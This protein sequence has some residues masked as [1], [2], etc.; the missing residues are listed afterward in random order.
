M[1]RGPRCPHQPVQDSALPTR[2]GSS[3]RTTSSHAADSTA[4]NCRRRVGLRAG[5]P[6]GALPT[7]WFVV[8]IPGS[9]QLTDGDGGR[10]RQEHPRSE[11]L[12]RCSRGAHPTCL[13]V[14]SRYPEQP[15]SAPGLGSGR[16]PAGAASC[17]V[18]GLRPSLSASSS[19]CPGTGDSS[20]GNELCALSGGPGPTLAQLLS[21]GPGGGT[22]EENSAWG[23]LSG[24]SLAPPV[25]RACLGL[26]QLQSHGEQAASALS[27]PGRQA[28]GPHTRPEAGPG[29]RRGLEE[30]LGHTP[31]LSLNLRPPGPLESHLG[32]ALG[33]LGPVRPP[34]L[35]S[36]GKAAAATVGTAKQTQDRTFIAEH[37]V[38]AREARLAVSP[39]AGGLREDRAGIA[40]G[41]PAG[42]PLGQG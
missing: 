28:K 32:E 38:P 22:L 15:G 13:G 40:W 8:Q 33:A 42:H 4:V 36:A 37:K 34:A 9:S 31:H 29:G 1:H 23:R 7:G 17:Q 25:L 12:G 18:P 30:A 27:H 26:S 16:L 20:G 5:E 6:E 39:A 19:R 11:A 2:A 14:R 3:S 35:C 24:P 41:S 10:R 21:R